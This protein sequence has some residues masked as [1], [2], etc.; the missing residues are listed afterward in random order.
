M[1]NVRGN[2]TKT[3]SKIIPRLRRNQRGKRLQCVCALRRVFSRFQRTKG[4]MWIMST[5]NLKRISVTPPT[6]QNGKRCRK[7]HCYERCYGVVLRDEIVFLQQALKVHYAVCY[8]RRFTDP[9]WFGCGITRSQMV[10][11]AN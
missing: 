11:C 3:Q 5:Q 4:I 9:Y 8:L 6:L 1:K 7:K 2:K 10:N